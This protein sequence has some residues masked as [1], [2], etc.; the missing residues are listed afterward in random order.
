MNP[1]HLN[2]HEYE[3]VEQIIFSL[4]QKEIRVRNQF[5]F[6]LD[7]LIENQSEI[8]SLEKTVLFLLKGKFFYFPNDFLYYIAK[9]HPYNF[10]LFKFFVEHCGAN[11]FT[12]TKFYTEQ[13]LI[14]ILMDSL[15]RDEYSQLGKIIEY[16]FEKSV[17]FLDEQERNIRVLIYCCLHRK[18][19]NIYDLFKRVLHYCPESCL[20]H[21]LDANA[22]NE[23][24]F[25]M[26]YIIFKSGFLYK[27]KM[28]DESSKIIQH[29]F[30]ICQLY[31]FFI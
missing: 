5:L 12:K 19:Q 17:D 11:I 8:T 2:H 25:W 27:E 31:S 1:F 28:N 23:K 24:P 21:A 22:S 15:Y 20:F 6:Y 26:L 16:I 18:Y 9:K 3:K 13:A 10:E 7:Q 29:Y 14:S 30:H 4:E